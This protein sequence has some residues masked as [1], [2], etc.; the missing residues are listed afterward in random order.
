M[1]VVED[2]ASL[3]DLHPGFDEHYQDHKF[4]HHINEA[5]ALQPNALDQSGHFSNVNALEHG[6][7]TFFPVHQN[8]RWTYFLEAWLLCLASSF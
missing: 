8:F 1:K 3:I 4:F 7:L 6:H 2:D 5:I